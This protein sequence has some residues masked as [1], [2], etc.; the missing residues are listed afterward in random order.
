MTEI[1]KLI[2]SLSISGS[3]LIL[4]M[5]IIKLFTK[6]RLSKGWQY[7]IW[8]IVIARLLLP[9]S[10]E[11]SLTGMVMDYAFSMTSSQSQPMQIPN[12]PSQENGQDAVVERN[13][14]AEQNQVQADIP[15]DFPVQNLIHTVLEKLWIVWLVVTIG[16]L[17]RKITVYQSFVKYI[18][19]GKKEL[20]DV[21]LWEQFGRL[22]EQSGVKRAV[23]VYSNSLISSPLLIGFFKPCIMLP[24]AR[25][26]EED[27]K[28]T[29]L[30]ELTHYRRLDMFYKWL[31]QLT[32]CLH[33]FNPFVY[34][35]NREISCACEL[36]CDEAVIRPLD[37]AGKLAYG[38]MLLN[39]LTAGGTYK[40]T[41]A[42]VTLVESKELLNERLD[43]IMNQKKK[44]KRIA[45][46][47]LLLSCLLIC[48]FVLIGAYTP[49]RVGET[50]DLAPDPQGTDVSDASE[51]AITSFGE[52]GTPTTDINT[53]KPE[54][55][56]TFIR[57]QIGFFSNQYI[58]LMDATNKQGLWDDEL[59]TTLDSTAQVVYFAESAKEH[60][61]NV[62]VLNA[63]SD[64]MRESDQFGQFRGEGPWFYQITEVSGPYTQ[65]Q[66]ALAE[67]FYNEGNA[68][69][70]YAVCRGLGS[71]TADPLIRRSID[72]NRIDY[73]SA[74][75]DGSTNTYDKN[76][77]A[78]E[79]YGAKR[80]DFFTVILEGLSE[81]KRTE[82]FN[83]AIKEDRVDF[84]SMLL[85]DEDVEYNKLGAQFYQEDR[86]DFFSMLID[87]L[88][89]DELK[90][91]AEQAYQDGNIVFFSI[92]LDELSDEE[93]I[94]FGERALK[95]GK[96]EL[97]YV[98]T[99]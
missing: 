25:L 2:L 40:D 28:Y 58:I 18:K 20:P 48:G 4:L 14:A 43:A 50:V 90:Q 26:S 53:A 71:D 49:P 32:L 89:K 60:A 19:A 51:S 36:S 27:F 86:I 37:S 85:T 78:E 29:I 96:T 12:D 77:L 83:R 1:L 10:P 87:H 31:V 94:A 84:F 23:A 75:M 39:A 11:Q 9:F 95:D 61:S 21:A 35:M 44:T 76:I 54:D 5:L 7:Y 65:T 41:L 98:T 30:H 47:A 97:Y 55:S 17:I 88:S 80:I 73:F 22:V 38:T 72:D 91:Y 81:T 13:A 79:F 6:K 52:T 99:W 66:E 69:Y 24:T 16:L 3:L 42:S 68:K 59:S 74:L 57:K 62:S 56:M 70:F 67:Q 93:R 33:W 46:T 34:V 45:A 63:F 64:A 8:L 15:A 82:L 92:A